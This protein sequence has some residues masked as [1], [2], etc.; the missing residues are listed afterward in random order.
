GRAYALAV[1][2]V[3]ALRLLAE[4]IRTRRR[5]IDRTIAVEVEI[6]LTLV[7][8]QRTSVRENG[9]TQAELAR[10]AEDRELH[11]ERAAEIGRAAERIGAVVAAHVTRSDAGRSEAAH[12]RR[13]EEEV[14]DDAQ[15][16]AAEG[17]DVA[18]LHLD[19]ADDVVEQLMIV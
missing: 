16:V 17:L 13:A 11:L 9:T 3:E 8:E 1:V 6:L 7:A 5:A 19:H 18:A 2:D 14:V 4:R 15:V 12:Q 10:Q